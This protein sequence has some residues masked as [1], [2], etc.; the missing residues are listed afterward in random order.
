MLGVLFVC[1]VVIPLVVFGGGGNSCG[2]DDSPDHRPDDHDHPDDDAGAHDD[3]DGND[4]AEQQ[5]CA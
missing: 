2:A 4:D 1:A 5:P 3:H